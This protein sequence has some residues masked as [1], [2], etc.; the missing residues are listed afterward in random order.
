MRKISLIILAIVAICAGKSFA[1]STGSATLST[2]IANV[3][4]M[5][6]TSAPAFVFDDETDYTS[7]MTVNEPAAI[8]VTSNRPFDVSVQASA[9]NLTKLLS[10]DVIAVSNF[11]VNASG[12]DGN[13][14]NALA[15][16]SSAQTIVDEAPAATLKAIDLSYATSG[17]SAFL[18]KETGSYTVT[19]TYTAS[20]D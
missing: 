20:V 18:G 19:L 8:T 16:S 5:T 1:Q 14:V 4:V 12:D 7:G 13:A 15:L 9:A 17:G 6:Y 3:L 10:A 11:T 2:T